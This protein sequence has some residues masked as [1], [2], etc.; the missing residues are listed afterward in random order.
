MLFAKTD[1]EEEN[2]LKHNGDDIQKHLKANS[3]VSGR[4]SPLFSPHGHL[5]DQTARTY[6]S[7]D[8]TLGATTD[9]TKSTMSNQK[10]AYPTANL[11]DA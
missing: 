3:I 11:K 9:Q 4:V 2:I 7:V 10:Q 6:Q 8:F 5:I 1:E